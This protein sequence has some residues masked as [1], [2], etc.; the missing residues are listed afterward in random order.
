MLRLET[1]RRMKAIAAILAVLLL[2][3]APLSVGAAEGASFA[4]A[5]LTRAKAAQTDA[6]WLQLQKD[7]QA[8]VASLPPPERIEFLSALA[9]GIASQVQSADRE[10]TA[11]AAR[12][13]IGASATTRE[14]KAQAFSRLFA[15]RE[16]EIEATA[17]RLLI[18][19]EVVQ[20]PNAEGRRDF[21]VYRR[22]LEEGAGVTQSRLIIY[23]FQ[24]S[25]LDAASWFVEN[26]ELPETERAMLRAEL[27]QA[28]QIQGNEIAPWEPAAGPAMNNADRERKLRQW[29]ANSSWILQ[30]LAKSLLEK[31][32]PWQTPDLQ[33][34][35]QKVAA[36]KS[37]A[38]R[39]INPASVPG[40]SNPPPTSVHAAAPTASPVPTTPIAQT[41]AVPVER[42]S[43]VWPWLVGIL[44]LLVIVALALKRRA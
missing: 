28:R 17:E 32:P 29:I 8:Q 42:E 43:A 3:M 12:F 37:V 44:V 39:P 40:V 20:T 9:M 22:A 33:V 41:P 13:L 16:P 36:P 1:Y 21:S 18:D 2:Y 31:Y 15:S 34:A 4:Q 7:V 11:E 6:A 26:I 27:G 24:R 23:L 5:A 35:T 25:P 14:E 38:L 10:R 30:L 19:I